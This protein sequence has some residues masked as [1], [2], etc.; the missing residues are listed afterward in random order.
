MQA[1]R[2]LAQR[3]QVA[4]ADYLA[5]RTRE[6]FNAGRIPT[7]L[8]FEGVHRRTIRSVLCMRGLSWPLADRVAADV[9]HEVLLKVVAKRPSWAEGQPEWAIEAGTL[10]ERTRCVHCHKGLPEGHH[11]FCGKLCRTAHGLRMMRMRDA[12][13][14]QMSVLATR[15]EL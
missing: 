12:T 7:L 1:K 4:L 6:A 13:E 9:V 10:I 3:K 2:R 14:D 8:S 11:K 15:Y 5:W